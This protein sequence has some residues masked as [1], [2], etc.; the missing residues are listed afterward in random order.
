[1]GSSS[2]L[3]FV[4][5]SFVVSFLRTPRFLSNQLV[6]RAMLRM[7]CEIGAVQISPVYKLLGWQT[8]I[9]VFRHDPGVRA[10]Q[11]NYNLYRIARMSTAQPLKKLVSG[12][13]L[14][15]D[16]TLLNTGGFFIFVCR[17]HMSFHIL[18]VLSPVFLLWRQFMKWAI[19]VIC[20]SVCVFYIGQ[21]AI[22]IGSIL[23]RG[24][25]FP[26]IIWCSRQTLELSGRKAYSECLKK[27]WLNSYFNEE[28]D[29]YECLNNLV[30]LPMLKSILLTNLLFSIHCRW[31][32]K[33]DFKSIL[34]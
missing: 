30:S 27:L 25:Y 6:K 33:W 31:H 9:S 10:L 28:S 20:A 22:W 12:V 26:L 5:R 4:Y 24:P 16:G 14:D 17:V 1:M 19:F 8:C 11:V 32:C 29:F 23:V 34:G 2:S 3:G 7:G 13:V 15:L 18:A 21:D